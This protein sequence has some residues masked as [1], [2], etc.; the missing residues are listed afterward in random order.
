MPEFTLHDS[1]HLFRV[2][3]LM[4]KLLNIRNIEKLN[5]PELMLLIL[6]S[7]FHD[8][9]MAPEEKSIIAWRKYWDENP[10]FSDKRKRMNLICFHVFAQVVQKELKR[11]KTSLNMG[12]KA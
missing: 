12:N 2:L 8:I 7:F 5:I 1:E 6:T 4:E 11:L 3:T 9:G 10:E